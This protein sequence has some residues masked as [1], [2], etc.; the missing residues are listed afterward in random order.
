MAFTH[1]D[2]GVIIYGVSYV[3]VCI[4]LAYFS[5]FTRFNLFG[6]ATICIFI[7][8]FAGF[9]LLFYTFVEAK[10]PQKVMNAMLSY[11]L[12]ILPDAKQKLKTA[13]TLTDEEYNKLASDMKSS[14]TKAILD[15][16]I[17]KFVM[18]NAGLALV[19]AVLH[20]RPFT[21]RFSWLT[22]PEYK[23]IGIWLSAVALQVLLYFLVVNRHSYIYKSQLFGYGLQVLRNSVMNTVISQAKAGVVDNADLQKVSTN[24]NNIINAQ[25]K[26]DL[27]IDNMPSI[28]RRLKDLANTHIIILACLSILTIGYTVFN[29]IIS[30]NRGAAITLTLFISI[31]CYYMYLFTSVKNLNIKTSLDNPD[32]L[33][34]EIAK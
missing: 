22:L 26:I 9:Q 25:Q 34:H 24:L 31:I 15:S 30:D 19:F 2:I 14:N 18:I 29:L 3:I 7:A 32:M 33:L 23:I 5:K 27:D 16:S 4:L 6:A 1:Q 8:S 21:S 28:A 20:M 13:D 11:F 12:Q 10:V 17:F